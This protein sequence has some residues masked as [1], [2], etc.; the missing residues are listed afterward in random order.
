[1]FGFFF[2]TLAVSKAK[3]LISLMFLLQAYLRNENV[4]AMDRLHVHERVK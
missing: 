3:E 1:M 4:M 2:D